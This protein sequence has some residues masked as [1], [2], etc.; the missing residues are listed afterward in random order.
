MAETA[1]EE[2]A[3]TSCDE[4]SKSITEQDVRRYLMQFILQC[5]GVVSEN[6]LLSSYLA[7]EQDSGRLPKGEPVVLAA[8]KQKLTE[9][10]STLNL[11]LNPLNYKISMV[12]H[13]MGKS[14]VS[15]RF[16]SLIT[17][18]VDTNW[19]RNARFYV[20]SNL[21]HDFQLQLATS[22]SASDIAFLKWAIE[23]MLTE[24]SYVQRFE[25][26]DITSDV[27]DEVDNVLRG[28]YGD[29]EYT[30]L[31]TYVSYRIGVGA[32]MTTKEITEARVEEL[33]VELAERRWIYRSPDG[34]IGLDIKFLIE[35][36]E[37]LVENFDVPLCVNCKEVVLQ[38]IICLEGREEF[39][40]A[41]HV[42]CLE[43]YVKHVN[44]KCPGSDKTFQEASAYAIG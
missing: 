25:R 30:G 35:M 34:K 8:W 4:Q 3:T 41:F 40:H 6:M 38:G 20:Y 1:N 13:P 31:D 15:R 16:T 29:D 12:N 22:F 7:L 9:H 43:H 28:K 44:D 37:Y 19:P 39:N 2:I 17:D 33:L 24:S 23:K 21:K 10:I 11:H 36:K 14:Y 42:G 27:V 5:K 32:L 26:D 18:I